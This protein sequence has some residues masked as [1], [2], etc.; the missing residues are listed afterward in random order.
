M[1]S[2][3]ILEYHSVSYM[4]LTSLVY[5]PTIQEFTSI[6]IIIPVANL[7]VLFLVFFFH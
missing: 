2:V 7:A 3:T 4:E 6:M 1:H 5:P